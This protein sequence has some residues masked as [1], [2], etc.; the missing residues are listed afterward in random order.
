MPD[1]SCQ[2]VTCNLC[3]DDV[4]QH[5]FTVRSFNVVKCL[6]CGLVYLNP[7]PR[8]EDISKI[9]DTEEYYSATESHDGLTL[10]YPN[11]VMLKDH[12]RFVADELLIGGLWPRIVQ[13]RWRHLNVPE[14]LYFFSKNTLKRLLENTGFSHVPGNRDR[15]DCCGDIR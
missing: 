11:Y 10:G 4:C 6:N 12:L 14:H 5:L 8:P 9:Y 15:H 7:M 1:I 3:Q 2:S 13:G